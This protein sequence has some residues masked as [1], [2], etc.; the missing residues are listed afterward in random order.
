MLCQ[1]YAEL[2]MVE[3]QAVLIMLLPHV[4]Q[5]Y[6]CA[7]GYEAAGFGTAAPFGCVIWQRECRHS[8]SLVGCVE[9]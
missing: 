9:L 7:T 5:L 4:L 6:S 1:A 8:Q 3:C 2:L